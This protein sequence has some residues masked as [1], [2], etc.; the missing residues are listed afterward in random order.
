MISKDVVGGRGLDYVLLSL[1]L[2]L[3]S[4]GWLMIYSVGHKQNYYD[5]LT[6]SEFLVKTPVGK[7]SIFIAAAFIV[8]LFVFSV[9]WKFW[10]TFA[11]PIYGLGIL[12]LIMV[13]FL[14]TKINGA[15]AWF[16]FGGFGF[17]PAEV[18]KIGT[19]LALCSFLSSPSSNLKE[20]RTQIIMG[21]ILVLP[22]ML[23]MLQP[24]AGSCL[25][26]FSFSIMLYREG[27]SPLPYLLAFSLALIFVLAIIFEANQLVLYLMSLALG[28]FVF[29][30]SEK[31]AW[32][33]A[34]TA[35]V[36]A[37]AFWL[38]FNQKTDFAMGLALA[39]VLVYLVVHSRRGR[40]KMVII[41]A[42]GLLGAACI[43]YVTSFAFNTLLQKH[44][45][46][47]INVW[48]RPEIC[49]PRGAAYNLINSKMAIGS[50]GFLGKGFRE[51]TMT[52]LSYVPEQ[53]TD[54]IFCTIGEEQGFIG[55]FGVLAIFLLFLIRI[56][57]VA[58]RQK[59]NFARLYGY[60]VAGILFF[61]FLIN[62]GMTMG[63]LPVIGIP[64]P[65]I[66]AGGSSLLGF[67]ALLAILLQLDSNRYSV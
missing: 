21:G 24:D 12:L 7:Q 55:V 25:V 17:Q 13:L 27:L 2:S 56:I 41:T 60:G 46:E 39:A 53:H 34:A 1:Y 5:T 30:I 65:F 3:I 42:V 61:H 29:N 48:L 19:C 47:R 52:K 45:Q 59:S 31:R 54:F 28:I 66:S 44:Q 11:Y 20:R 50:G 62:I 16:S 6:W 51:G 40:F 15:R 36:L 10:R 33:G 67:S 63:L 35:A 23:I 18:A 32:W 57:I 14:G 64:L 58:E 22:M 8:T 49:D 9:D 43:V 38:F 4:I 26:F 37:V